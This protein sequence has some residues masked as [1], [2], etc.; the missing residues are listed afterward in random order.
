MSFILKPS[1]NHYSD[2]VRFFQVAAA[3]QQLDVCI[4]IAAALCDGNNMIKFEV[5]IRATFSASSAV[6]LPDALSDVAWN[7]ARSV[8]TFFAKRRLV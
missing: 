5:I 4:R 7:V 6:P 1:G 3:T 8:F 2:V